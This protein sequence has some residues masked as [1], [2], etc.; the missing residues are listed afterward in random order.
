MP[1]LSISYQFQVLSSTEY[2][3]LKCLPTKTR[4]LKSWPPEGP[5]NVTIFGDRVFEVIRETVI[6]SDGYASEKRT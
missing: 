1:D 6:Q 3:R 4:M 2:H 5:Q